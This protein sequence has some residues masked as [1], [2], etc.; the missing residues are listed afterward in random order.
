MSRR[1][2]SCDAP[3]LAGQHA[4]DFLW[5]K[6]SLACLDESP[7]NAAAH[8]VKETIPLDDE[9]QQGTA[10]F[11]VTASESSRGCLF[12]ITLVGGE[13]T[14]VVFAGEEGG[15]LA[16]GADVERTRDMPGRVTDQRIHRRMVPHE[17][18]IL[19]P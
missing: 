9:G 8:F 1:S 5:R 14:E 6:A 12:C 16:H 10:C 7:D 18:A 2:H 13:G 3:I 19:F 4:L 11:E 17:K 15:G